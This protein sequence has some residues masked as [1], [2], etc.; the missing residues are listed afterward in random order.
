[1]MSR[2]GIYY[3]TPFKVHQG[4]AQGGTIYPTIFNM[5]VDVVIRNW[6][7]LVVEEEAGPDGFGSEIQCLAG[8]FY[9]NDGLLT[10][11]RSDQLQAALYFLMGLFNSFNLQINVDNTIGMVCQPYFIVDRHLEISYTRRKAVLGP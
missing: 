1:M 9:A 11:P 3:S 4:V 7:T 2:A 6:V 5:V 10:S 8:F